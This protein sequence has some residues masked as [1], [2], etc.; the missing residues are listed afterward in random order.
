MPTGDT[1]VDKE[2][3]PAAS[4]LKAAS[5]SAWSYEFTSVLKLNDPPVMAMAISTASDVL[6]INLPY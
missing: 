3:N 6:L 4:S 2:I 1:F 5:C